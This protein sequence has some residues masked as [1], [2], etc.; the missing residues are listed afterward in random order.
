ML[1]LGIFSGFFRDAFRTISGETTASAG[2][3]YSLLLNRAFVRMRLSRFR[4]ALN[5]LTRND[6]RATRFLI[7]RRLNVIF[8][9]GVRRGEDKPIET[10]TLRQRLLGLYDDLARIVFRALLPFRRG[11]RTPLNVLRNLYQRSLIY[12][13]NRVMTMVST[14]VRNRSDINAIRLMGYVTIFVNHRLYA[15]RTHTNCYRQIRLRRNLR[16]QRLLLRRD[17]SRSFRLARNS[18]YVRDRLLYDLYH[19]Y[20]RLTSYRLQLTGLRRACSA[21][22]YCYSDRR[23]RRYFILSPKLL[24]KGSARD[25]NFRRRT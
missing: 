22:S 18:I 6:V 7:Y 4:L 8:V 14:T 24:K 23:I 21:I 5:R 2:F 10:V 13:V 3:L 19:T 1:S 15:I 20:Y 9:R 11:T 12:T 25:S 16:D 17:I